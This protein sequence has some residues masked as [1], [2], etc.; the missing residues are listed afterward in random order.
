MSNIRLT[1]PNLC[2]NSA[3]FYPLTDLSYCRALRGINKFKNCRITMRVKREDCEIVKRESMK[4]HCVLLIFKVKIELQNFKA[5]PRKWSWW[6][7]FPSIRPL[8]HSPKVSI[9]LYIHP[10]FMAINILCLRTPFYLE[11]I[12]VLIYEWWSSSLSTNHCT[13]STYVIF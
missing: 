11:G 9:H 12:F 6:F 13:S 3:T 7:I 8:I 5:R 1:E 2:S 4:Q 10:S